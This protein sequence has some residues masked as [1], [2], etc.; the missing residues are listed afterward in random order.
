VEKDLIKCAQPLFAAHGGALQQTSSASLHTAL[1]TPRAGNAKAHDEDA[2]R[3]LQPTGKFADN[4]FMASM[5]TSN[6]KRSLL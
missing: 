1:A 4:C 6:F 3:D 5:P 2:H